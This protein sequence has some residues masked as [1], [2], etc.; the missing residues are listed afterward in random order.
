MFTCP[1]A[2]K[3]QQTGSFDGSFACL[4]TAQQQHFL[5]SVLL[6]VCRQSKGARAAAAA[7][8]AW[9]YMLEGPPDAPLF[10]ANADAS[11][12]VAQLLGADVVL[13]TYDVLQQVRMI[14]MFALLL[15]V[16]FVCT[17]SYCSSSASTC[18]SLSLCRCWCSQ[19]TMR[20][21]RKAKPL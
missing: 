5:L 6:Y 13:T 17:A 3:C 9:N 21:S 14:P 15:S 2:G 20:C 16:S 19:P 10:D 4:I 8:A 11:A 1:D 18:Y 7:V 12:A